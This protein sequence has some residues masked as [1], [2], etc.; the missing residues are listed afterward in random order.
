M[1]FRIRGSI[2]LAVA[3]T[4]ASAADAQWIPTNVGAGA[5]AE[6]RESAPTQNR[7]N[8][9]EIASRVK[10]D[11][12]PPDPNDGGDRNSLFYVRIDLA[13]V[14]LPPNFTTAFRLTYRNDNLQGRR[15]RDEATP[16]LA[17]RAGMALYGLD[18]ASPGV[19]WD[20][21]TITYLTA[22]GIA[23]DGDVGTRDQ[24][25]DLVPLAEVLFPEIGTQNWLP[26]GGTLLFQSP[27]LDQFV[28]DALAGGAT[29]VTFAV[30]T[31]HDATAPSPDWINF[32]YLFNPKEQTTLNQDPSYDADVTDP[33]NP[34]GSPWSGADNSTGDFSPALRIDEVLIPIQAIPA[35]DVVGLGMLALL[36]AWFALA[37]LRAQ[38]A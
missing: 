26:V 23:P 10:N 34:L 38:R 21:L 4:L 12:V 35:A 16:D 15:I 7:G 22:P 25:A 2:A 11:F 27:E 33:N 20:E 32:N 18:P 19:A 31:I 29:T 6:V 3:T 30:H 36:V 24:T 28:A 13:G 5:D 1:R 8:S 9:T 17:T 37:R 14:T